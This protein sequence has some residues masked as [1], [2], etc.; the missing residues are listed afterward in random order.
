MKFRWLLLLSSFLSV[1]FSSLPAEAR[2][3]WS[4]DRSQNRLEFTTD[5]GVQPKAELIFNPTRL[6]I[7]LPGIDLGRPTA[8]QRVGGSIR[9]LR[10]GQFNSQTTRIVIELAPGYTLNPQ[11]VKFRG[12]ST[13]QWTVQLPTPQRI[14]ASSAPSP[15][16][17]LSNSQEDNYPSSQSRQLRESNPVSTSR[18]YLD[19]FLVTRDGFYIRTRGGKPENIEVERSRNRRRIDIEVV[20]ATLSRG[21]AER[22][23][24]LNRYGVSQIQFSQD[25]EASLPVVRIRMDVDRES[26]DWLA[27]F[28]DAGGIV[29]WP[30]GADASTLDKQSGVLAQPNNETRIGELSPTSYQLFGLMGQD[31]KSLVLGTDSRTILLLEEK[32]GKFL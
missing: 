21:L 5:R 12:L 8:N 24:R 14:G 23:L 10:I 22:D 2:L 26:P 30:R 18:L 28:S 3:Y 1:I 13:N 16:S 31:V 15:S 20:G 25:R 11:Q 29:L 6:V 27:S 4:F 32:T 19:S 17:R 9:E 7:D